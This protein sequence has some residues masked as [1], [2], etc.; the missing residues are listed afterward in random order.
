MTFTFSNDALAELFEGTDVELRQRWFWL[1][2]SVVRDGERRRIAPWSTRAEV[3]RYLSGYFRT[4][5]R[6]S[7]L[8]L[9]PSEDR[10]RA[11][12]RPRGDR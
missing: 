8:L 3:A 6:P 2:V 4:K 9:E 11:T 7:D 12:V 5:V 10:L 1:E